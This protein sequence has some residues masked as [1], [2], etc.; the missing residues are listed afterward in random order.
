MIQLK[1]LTIG[2]AM[3]DIITIIEDHDVERVTLSNA[4]TSFLLVEPGRT[5]G[6]GTVIAAGRVE[7]DIHLVIHHRRGDVAMQRHLHHR[8]RPRR[9]R[10]AEPGVR[11]LAGA[12]RPLPRGE[13]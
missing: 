2:S 5:Q 6:E 1:A 13:D 8:G 12:A 7:V 4:T 11:A 9:G 10:K 3:V